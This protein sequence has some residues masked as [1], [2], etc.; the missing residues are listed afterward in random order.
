[1]LLKHA[2]NQ[3]NLFKSFSCNTSSIVMNNRAHELQSWKVCRN[4]FYLLLTYTDLFTSFIEVHLIQ[5][6]C[7]ICPLFPPSQ[8][9]SFMAQLNKTQNHTTRINKSQFKLMQRSYF[10]HVIIFYERKFIHTH[11]WHNRIFEKNDTTR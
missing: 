9:D 5:F 6:V 1:M 4:C 7:F 8:Y 11:S 10:S 2:N 3:C